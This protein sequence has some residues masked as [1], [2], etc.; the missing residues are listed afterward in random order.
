MRTDRLTN[1]LTPYTRLCGFFL[2]VKFATSL[3]AWLT[4]PGDYRIN[5][6]LTKKQKTYWHHRVVTR[7]VVR[8]KSANGAKGH[9]FESPHFLSFFW[10][11]KNLVDGTTT[12]ITRCRKGW[13]ES[14][15]TLT[16]WIKK[17]KLA[18]SKGIWIGNG[19]K[20]RNSVWACISIKWPRLSIGAALCEME[21]YATHFWG[22]GK[23]FLCSILLLP[24][25]SFT[26][27]LP[28]L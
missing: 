20:K 11:T 26:L 23:I 9:G 24:Q 19:Y 3:L 18:G 21:C 7:D 2:S 16:T 15:R 17:R 14:A 12:M 4:G 28:L 27:L 6:C 5:I 13:L 22:W 10:R 8:F 1:S 25:C